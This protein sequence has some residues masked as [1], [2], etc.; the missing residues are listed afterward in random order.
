[1]WKAGWPKYA[2]CN[3]LLKSP[4]QRLLAGAFAPLYSQSLVE[5][6]RFASLRLGFKIGSKYIRVGFFQQDC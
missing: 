5:N 6:A 4:F 2:I 3:G 1:M